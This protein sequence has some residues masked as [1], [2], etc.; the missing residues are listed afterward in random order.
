[1]ILRQRSPG[2]DMRRLDTSHPDF[3]RQLQQLTAWQEDLDREVAQTV[4][5]IIA[6]VAGRGDAAVL[7]YTARFDGLDAGSMAELELAPGRLLAALERIAPEQ[8]QALEYAATRIRSFHEH[9]SQQSWQYRDEAG[10]LLGQKITPLERAGIYVPGGKAS[11]PSSVL[12]TALPARVA[13][14]DEIVMVVPAPGGVLNDLVLAAAQIAGVDRVFT[15]GGA[16]A[17][18]RSF[19][20]F[21]AEFVLKYSYPPSHGSSVYLQLL[22]CCRVGASAYCGQK[23]A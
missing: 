3:E 7:E 18:Q 9:Q 15:I 12:M 16:Q 8:R 6:D 19:Q 1:M 10:N 4:S 5:A 23:V 22:A 20:Q 2:P 11:Y 21:A 14:V 13:G 17:V